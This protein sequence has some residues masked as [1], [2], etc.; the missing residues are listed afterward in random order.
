[1]TGLDWVRWT[2]STLAT[3]EP[4]RDHLTALVT[5]DKG[6]TAAAQ[7]LGSPVSSPS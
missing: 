5:Y 1:M 3:A 2:R 7:D 4:L 6:L